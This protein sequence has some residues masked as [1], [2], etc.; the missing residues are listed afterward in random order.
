MIEIGDLIATLSNYMT[1]KSELDQCRRAAI[2]GVEYYCSN[3]SLELQLAEH[4]L[5]KAL[6]GYIDQRIAEAGPQPHKP[7]VSAKPASGSAERGLVTEVE[8]ERSHR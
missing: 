8:I 3:Y 4:G 6:N 7:V 5:A 2:G 1:A